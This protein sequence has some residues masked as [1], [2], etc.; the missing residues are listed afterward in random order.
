MAVSEWIEGPN[1]RVDSA[2]EVLEV[3]NEIYKWIPNRDQ[4]RPTPASLQ[5]KKVLIN[6][7]QTQWASL[8]DYMLA[9]IFQRAYL[10]NYVGQ[11]YVT[12]TQ[13]CAD[14][15]ETR[16]T[17]NDFPYQIEHPEGRHYVLWYSTAQRSPT[18]S[19]AHI[20]A[21]IREHL[22]RVCGDHPFT[23][24]WYENP[25]MSVPDLY[26]VQV[27]WRSSLPRVPAAVPPP[28]VG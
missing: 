19:D 27:F 14:V 15:H 23:W 22:A 28:L 16:F 7:I 4:V 13:P 2:L 17:P 3:L 5:A 21:H 25:K 1:D 10:V 11:K 9:I 6:I 12:D 20:N 24:A 18:L 8:R 26:H